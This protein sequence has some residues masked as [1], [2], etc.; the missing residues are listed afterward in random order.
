MTDW[1][2]TITWCHDERVGYQVYLGVLLLHV[3]PCTYQRDRFIFE[4]L[5]SY[6][7]KDLPIQYLGVT[8]GERSDLM[9]LNIHDLLRAQV[10]AGEI[11]E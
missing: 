1:G 5:A 3:A 2:P 11:I 7:A 8:R 9:D 6:A 4:M 10:E